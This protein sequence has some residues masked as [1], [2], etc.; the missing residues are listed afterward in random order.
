MPS[1]TSPGPWTR[2]P[3][4]GAASALV[5]QST[6]ARRPVRDRPSGVRN[7]AQT[8]HPPPPCVT[9]NKINTYQWFRDRVHRLG[10]DHDPADRRAA[11]ARA[12]EEDRFPVGVF[13]VNPS[14]PVWPPRK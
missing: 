5:A 1:A 8:D 14:L 12:T 10:Q 11:F 13:Y 4:R 7:R 2:R 3:T 6:A 9:F